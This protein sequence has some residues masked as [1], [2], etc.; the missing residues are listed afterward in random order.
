V[1]HADGTIAEGP[2]ALCEVQGYVYAARRAGAAMAAALGMPERAASLLDQAEK[3]KLAF[4]RN[5]WSDELG[6]YAMALDGEK[7]PCLVRSSNPG[8]CLFTEIVDPAYV[9]QLVSALLDDDSFSGWG[10]RTLAATERRYNPMGYHTGAVWPHDNAL[11]GRGLARYGYRKESARLLQAMFQASLH[12]DL[13]RMPELFCGFQR[14]PNESPVPYPVACAPQAWASGSVF[15]LLQACLGIHIEARVRRIE[16]DRPTLPAGL[17]ELRIQNL[18]V[19]GDQ[20]DVAVI[21]RRDGV[22]VT[23]LNG[24]TSVAIVCH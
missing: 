6:T 20:I 23:R 5:F 21:R 11:I 13:Q 3:L 17:T 9:D 7:R 24:S 22:D 8:Q 1:V 19:C 18:V 10:I 2:I 12:F 14:R 16:F 15:L 4:N